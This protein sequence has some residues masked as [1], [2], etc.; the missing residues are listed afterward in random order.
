M[1]S[2]GRSDGSPGHRPGSIAACAH[3]RY[4]ATRRQFDHYTVYARFEPGN[5]HVTGSL[6]LEWTN[7]TGEPHD[8]LPLRLYPNAAAY[9]QGGLEIAALTVN[10][11][12]APFAVT[13]DP[14]VAL[15]DLED[16][17][18][19]GDV[20]QVAMSFVTTIPTGTSMAV[21]VLHGDVESGWWLADWLPILAGWEPGYGWYLEPPGTLGNPTFAASAVWSLSLTMP[22]N[23]AVFGTGT[24][25][26]SGAGTGSEQI[27]TIE[28]PPS[29]DLT[30]VLLPLGDLVTTER[31]VGGIRVRLVLPSAPADPAVIDLVMDTAAEVLPFYMDTLGDLPGGE[32]D[33]VPADL[34]G[35][36]GIAWSGIIWLDL[37]QAMAGL[38]DAARANLRFI[39]AHELAH[40]WVPVVVG[41]NNNRHN[42]LSESLASHLA[43]LAFRQGGDQVAAREYL[44]SEVAAPY[45]ALL[46]SGRDGVVDDPV[47]STTATTD[48]VALVYGK[49]VL[50]FE[51]IRQQIGPEAYLQALN[52]YAVDFRFGI[53][54]PP[55]LQ[56][57]FENASGQDLDDLWHTWFNSATTTTSDVEEVLAVGQQIATPASRTTRK[58][59]EANQ[60]AVG[61]TVGRCHMCFTPPPTLVGSWT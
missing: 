60:R 17:A 7:T 61:F 22:S 46:E 38:D 50:G 11:A 57:A 48:R 21:N 18:S 41:S 26:D 28:T 34:A 16:Q 45:L 3:C 31:T 25:I 54:D 27:I 40:Q 4:P 43:V 44:A 2:T 59:G 6:R 29:R 13:G 14:T 24:V 23:L 58:F 39:L 33:L 52:A 35:S 10:G 53:T 47:A 12:P 15:V 49:G 37:D 20:I 36:G 56:A 5:R 8:Q 55:D 51:A 1:R 9:E 19:P 32:I 42:F 30:L